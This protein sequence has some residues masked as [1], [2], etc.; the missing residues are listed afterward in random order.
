[1]EDDDEFPSLA[2]FYFHIVGDKSVYSSTLDDLFVCYTLA[3][4]LQRES[5]NPPRPALPLELILRITRFSGFMDT[6]PDPALTLNLA[7]PFEVSQNPQIILHVSPKLSR[8]HLLFMARIHLVP[9]QLERPTNS[10]PVGYCV[11]FNFLKQKKKSEANRFV[12]LKVH[13]WTNC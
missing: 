13:I 3:R 12:Q 10:S 4:G 2:E 7:V 6:N 5:T 8:R 1:M 9:P 11:S